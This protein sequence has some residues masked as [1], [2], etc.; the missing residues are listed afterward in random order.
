MGASAISSNRRKVF[1]TEGGMSAFYHSINFKV[2]DA[3]EGLIKALRGS[4]LANVTFY[5]GGSSEDVVCDRIEITCDADAEII[6]STVTG[7]FTCQV[8]V[9]VITNPGDNT[10]AEHQKR[11][12]VVGDILFRDD[13]IAQIAALN[14]AVAD[15]TAQQW[16][17]SRVS[18]SPVGGEYATTFTG[19]L[20]CWPS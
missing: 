7:N 3:F 12:A 1:R 14:P 10:R 2:E 9:S 13:V 18:G 5:K 16:L 17:P 6:G 19:E 4:E 20:R 11:V 15:F 8:S